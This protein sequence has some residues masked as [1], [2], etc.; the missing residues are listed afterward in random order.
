MAFTFFFF[1]RERE[2][3]VFSFFVV[4]AVLGGPGHSVPCSRAANQDFYREKWHLPLFV[5]SD[6][7][8]VKPCAEERKKVLQPGGTFQAHETEVRQSQAHFM[9]G[10]ILA[11][12]SN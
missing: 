11:S 3:V 9:Q 2:K 10:H 8:S 6:I 1:P 4:L 5:L 12:H 7:N